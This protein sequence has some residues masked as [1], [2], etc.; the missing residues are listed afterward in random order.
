MSPV[1]SNGTINKNKQTDVNGDSRP[2]SEDYKHVN[3]NG[4]RVASDQ[5]VPERFSEAQ[6]EN[7]KAD[8]EETDTTTTSTP[9]KDHSTMDSVGVS[10]TTAATLNT[11]N[12]S[13]VPVVD[14]TDS[15]I[16]LYEEEEGEGEGEGEEADNNNGDQLD[17]DK[18]N[19]I[20]VVQKS[21]KVSENYGHVLGSDGLGITMGH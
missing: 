7:D 1:S 16:D 10:V 20:P 14:L 18:E 11:F 5:L 4:K 17:D 3:F 9:R 6:F 19:Q 13:R 2:A 21:G 15:M 8:N 12:V